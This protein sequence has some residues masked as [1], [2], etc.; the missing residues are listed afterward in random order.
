MLQELAM[1]H[2]R[3]LILMVCAG[4]I[5][6]ASLLAQSAGNRSW[7][8]LTDAAIA[9]LNLGYLS[10]N[11][12]PAELDQLKKS[13]EITRFHKGNLSTSL[14][15]I[16]E[17]TATMRNGHQNSAA[18]MNIE[19]LL[20]APVPTIAAAGTDRQK[21]FLALYNVLHR[22]KSME[23][24]EYYSESR[25]Q[26]RVFF[27]KSSLVRSPEDRSSLAD[28]V[29]AAIEPAHSLFAMQEDSTFGNNLYR[30]EIKPISQDGL[31]LRMQNM[32]QIWYGIV[33]VLAGQGLDMHV[34]IKLQGSWMIF[35][36]QTG[37]S[38]PQAFGIDEKAQN[39][40]YNRLVALYDWFV[41]ESRR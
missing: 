21:L 34:V 23:G 26:M 22:F 4:L 17:L 2:F 18:N 40:F 7:L 6:S 41:K 13:G 27:I 30:I 36:G 16:P 8:P 32:E 37:L 9:E 12:T 24:I 5:A 35:Y 28:P 33:P 1:Q 20:A 31:H 25:K 39:S 15:P 11:A 29:Y 14:C 19:T 3:Q 10:G 38:A